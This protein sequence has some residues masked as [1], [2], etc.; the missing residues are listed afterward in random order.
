MV[1]NTKNNGK[2]NLINLFGFSKTNSTKF[3]ELIF[4]YLKFKH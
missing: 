3:K 2:F 4:S 1:K